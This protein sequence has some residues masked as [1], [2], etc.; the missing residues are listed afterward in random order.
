MGFLLGAVVIYFL[1]SRLWSLF[2]FVL[3]AVGIVCFFLAGKS[4]RFI[5]G[6]K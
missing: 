1:G 4:M 5:N 6:P 3:K 2:L